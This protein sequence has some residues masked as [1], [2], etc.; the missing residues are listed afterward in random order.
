MPLFFCMA[1]LFASKWVARPWRSF[2][3]NKI[4]LLAWVFLIWQPVFFCFKYLAAHTLPDQSD[5]S[6]LAHLI[7]MLASPVRPNGETWFLW[8]LALYFV[9]AKILSRLPVWLHLA[10]ALMVS[11]G[12]TGVIRPELG[13]DIVR[14]M[15]AGLTNVL[16]LYVFFAVGLTLSRQ[17][18][19]GANA[20]PLW[21][22]Y[23]VVAVWAW[24]A[25]GVHSAGVGKAFGVEIGLKLLGI[26][27]G[28]GLRLILARVSVLVTLG[29]KTLPVYVGHMLVISLTVIALDTLG[30]LFP[31]GSAGGVVALAL[32]ALAVAASLGLA[33][34]VQ[35]TP[36]GYAYEQPARFRLPL[37]TRESTHR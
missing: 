31:A 16:A 4:A 7:R 34:V 6:L 2:L 25:F 24:C 26:L 20:A 10:L 29:Q 19:T 8:A 12:F 14:L 11:V 22:P 18:R 1:G 36:L 15:G 17:I 37:R 13:S 23:A 30:V 9:V 32:C 3:N 28:I 5:T 33:R 35:G 27:A 21:A